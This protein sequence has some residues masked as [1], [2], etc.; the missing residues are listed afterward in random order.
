MWRAVTSFEQIPVGTRV[1]IND[2][3]GMRYSHTQ[4]AVEK[5][6]REN[7]VLTWD[8]VLLHQASSRRPDSVAVHLLFDGNEHN[9]TYGYNYLEIGSDLDFE[10]I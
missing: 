1:R 8:E 10:V 9:M 5:F 7:L 6:E 3:A 2:K 4:A